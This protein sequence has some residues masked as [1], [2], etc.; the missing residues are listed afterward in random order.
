M[1]GKSAGKRRGGGQKGKWVKS[2][3]I[4]RDVHVDETKKGDE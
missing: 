3:G 4:E 2:M 1:K